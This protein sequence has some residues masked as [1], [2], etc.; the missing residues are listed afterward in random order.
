MNPKVEFIV[1][2]SLSFFIP[3]AGYIFASSYIEER[4]YSPET[5]AQY[6]YDNSRPDPEPIKL[7]FVGDIM[8]DRTLRKDGEQQGYAELFSC[9]PDMFAGYDEVIGNL[10]GTVTEYR[11]VSRDAPY[12]APE[13]FRF[14]F[15]PGAVRVLVDAG[16]GVVS[17][18]NNHIRDFGN[19]GI[20][21]TVANAEHMG[22]VTFGDPRP[23]AKRY[24]VHEVEGTRIAFVPYNQFMGTAEQTLADLAQSSAE[25]DMQVVFP[26]WGDEYVPAR[27]DTKQ[28]ARKFVD[29]GADLIIG[30]HPHVIQE[31]ETYNG[32]PI[33]YS[34]GNFIFD[35]YWEPAVST[36]MMVEIEMLDGKIVNQKE[37]LVESKRHSGTCLKQ[38]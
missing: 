22:L 8:L 23:D 6:I 25:S 18:A 37:I 15:D 26:H 14:T 7:L 13:S 34:L 30:A 10:E 19:D 32:T 12:E 17:L 1:I 2:V 24:V 29:A 31:S 28:L 3:V 11:S 9:L 21:Q 27:A 35:Q 36:G 33:Y 5:I 20:A 38:V 4:F 16:L